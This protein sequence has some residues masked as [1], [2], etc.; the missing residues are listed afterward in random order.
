MFVDP[1]ELTKS[2]AAWFICFSK[3]WVTGF[4]I[5]ACGIDFFRRKNINKSEKPGK[6]MMTSE[7]VRI[8]HPI[9]KKRRQILFW[10]VGAAFVLFISIIIGGLASKLAKVFEEMRVEIPGAI[11]LVLAL[12][13][14]KWILIPI[15][16]ALSLSG[17]LAIHRYSEKSPRCIRALKIMMILLVI[18]FVAAFII[19]IALSFLSISEPYT[20]L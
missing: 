10:S 18:I 8:S 15:W 7:T 19:L 20:D 11:R 13:K 17:A 1:V 14:A 2:T 6:P 4:T 3:F 9:S 12:D 16:L 5:S